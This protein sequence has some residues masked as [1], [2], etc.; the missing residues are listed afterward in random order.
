MHEDAVMIL[1]ELKLA[2]HANREKFNLDDT[3]L[4]QLEIFQHF[5][6]GEHEKARQI[7]KNGMQIHYRFNRSHTS[8]KLGRAEKPLK[9]VIKSGNIENKELD[10][11]LA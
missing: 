2:I 11:Q 6:D 7:E 4:K 3:H 1:E 8:T 10:N 9:D 5:L